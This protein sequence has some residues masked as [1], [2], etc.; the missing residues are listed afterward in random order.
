MQIDA[1]IGIAGN[2]GIS[3]VRLL[4]DRSV[5]VSNYLPFYTDLNVEGGSVYR[6]FSGSAGV[7][8]PTSIGTTVLWYLFNPAGSGNYV[9]PLYF[10]LGFTSGVLAAGT[11]AMVGDFGTLG[12]PTGGTLLTQGSGIQNLLLS[13]KAGTSVIRSLA[14]FGSTPT[15]MGPVGVI[16]ACATST[17]GLP[18]NESFIP[19][20]GSV[21][22]PPGTGFGF[23]PITG[24][25]TSPVVIAGCVYA[26]IP[27]NSL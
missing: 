1:V 24:A 13:N 14:T 20:E 16:Q 3:A 18:A 4:A 21:V 15:Y 17:P 8:M 6:S 25:G 27:V 23:T 12:A 2:G 26:E 11:L 22:S 9:V 19:L 10:I 7:A 5:A